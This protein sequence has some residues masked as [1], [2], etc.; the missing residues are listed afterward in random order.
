MILENV[1][2]KIISLL[3]A[4]ETSSNIAGDIVNGAI[5][6]GIGIGASFIPVVGPFVGPVLS[7]LFGVNGCIMKL[8]QETYPQ[9]LEAITLIKFA[10]LTGFS[11]Q[12][13]KQPT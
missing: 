11:I 1:S 9:V 5:G 12:C 13:P 3:P 6:M 7:G 10:S 4:K 2:F 8:K